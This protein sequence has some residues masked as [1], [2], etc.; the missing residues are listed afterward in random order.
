M[1]QRTRRLL[2]ATSVVG[3]LA[4]CLVGW[5]TYDFNMA[6]GPN[7]HPDWQPLWP[8]ALLNSVFYGLVT[9]VATVI[10][11]GGAPI[12]GAWLRDLVKRL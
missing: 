4:G 11:I 1:T 8:D 2:L 3:M 9:F 10:L 12:L 5:A 7:T 6:H